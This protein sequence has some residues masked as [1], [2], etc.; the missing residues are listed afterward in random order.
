MAVLSSLA[1]GALG[2]FQFR[3]K[4]RLAAVNIR[5]ASFCTWFFNLGN[6]FPKR[7][8]CGSKC[9][10]RPSKGSSNAKTPF[11]YSTKRGHVQNMWSSDPSIPQCLQHAAEVVGYIECSLAGVIYQC[12]RIL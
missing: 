9:K 12:V 1:E 7:N 8:V 11:Q 10:E 2:D 5:L 3:A 6:G 4:R